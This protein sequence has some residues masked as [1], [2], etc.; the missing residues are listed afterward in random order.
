MLFLAAI[1]VTCSY[2]GYVDFASAADKLVDVTD[3]LASVTSQMEQYAIN[4]GDQAELMDGYVED[5]VCTGMLDEVEEFSGFIEE[6]SGFADELIEMLDG[7]PEQMEDASAFIAGDGKD[8]M[9]AG[10]AL[11]TV[12]YWVLA[13]GGIIAA[14]TKC[15]GDDTIIF[16]FGS[17]AMILMIIFM[18]TELMLSVLLADF[19]YKGPDVAVLSLAKE[20][21]LSDLNM[22]LID[23]YTDCVGNNSL[24]T[25]LNDLNATIGS[26][27]SSL[28]GLGSYCDYDPA[29]TSSPISD[30]RTSLGVCGGFVGDFGDILACRNIQPLYAQVAYDIT[31]GDIV[32]GLNKMFVAQVV[33]T[34]FIWIA[35]VG[36]P[37][38]TYNYDEYE[39]DSKEKLY[40]TDDDF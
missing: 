31:C 8:K 37:C 27:S 14:F 33:S 22:E 15:K 17:L 40:P 4:L 23:F 28:G 30:I 16:C 6:F 13:V 18:G 29:G 26:L 34:F 25:N 9:T 12:M 38:A 19:C 11:L 7:V 35:F 32:F 2:L 1:T 24:A 20:A 36:F 5:A 3:E 39:E 21:G 10:V